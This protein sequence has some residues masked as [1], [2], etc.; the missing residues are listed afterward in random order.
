MFILII[1]PQKRWRNAGVMQHIFEENFN[2]SVQQ[3]KLIVFGFLTRFTVMH[4]NRHYVAEAIE[5]VH[6]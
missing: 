6:V 1:V 2:V 4:S 5:H 3:D